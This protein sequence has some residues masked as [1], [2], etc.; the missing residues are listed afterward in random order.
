MSAETTHSTSTRSTTI[1]T[2]STFNP[3]YWVLAAAAVACTHCR[4]CLAIFQNGW[5]RRLA[6]ALAVKLKYGVYVYF[7]GQQRQRVLVFG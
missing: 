3:G 7:A 1:T 6:N 4:W 2:A 5:K